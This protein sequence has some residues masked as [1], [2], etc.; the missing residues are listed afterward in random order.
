[1]GSVNIM[2]I[3]FMESFQGGKFL[4]SRQILRH[5]TLLSQF[6]YKEILYFLV[7]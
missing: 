4:Q 5:P 3:S 2:Y 7:M 6:A 1:M